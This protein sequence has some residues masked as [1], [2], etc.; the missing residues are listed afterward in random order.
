MKALTLSQPW[1]AL[2]A[3]GAKKVETRKWRPGENPGLIVIAS[4]KERM[5]ISRKQLVATE[6]FCS[7][8]AFTPI[9]YS[10]LLAVARLDHCERTEDVVGT[11]SPR[12]QAFGDYRPRRW[13][14]FLKDVVALPEPILIPPTPKGMPGI[15][16]LGLWDVPERLMTLDQATALMGVA[17]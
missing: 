13:A 9:I 16:G 2:V 7:A 10:S 12:E 3:S 4:S 14:W 11:L 5:N 15:A 1:A 6:P 17:K 8:L